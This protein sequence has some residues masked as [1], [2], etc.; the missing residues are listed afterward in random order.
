MKRNWIQ[1]TKAHHKTLLIV[2]TVV[3]IL[4]P[5]ILLVDPLIAIVVSF[6]ADSYD[7]RIFYF[8]KRT[9][10]QSWDKRLDAWWYICVLVYSFYSLSG[11]QFQI[12]LGLFLFRLLGQVA[13][14]V[15]KDERLFIVFP[16]IFENAFIAYVLIYKFS[17]LGILAQWPQSVLLWVI[18]VILKMV[19]EWI[20]HFPLAK[21]WEDRR[22]EFCIPKSA[23][24]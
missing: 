15:K 17:A 6:I 13:Y 5:A 20:V 10:Y 4:V 18:I 11:T 24:V 9:N 22:V 16:N 19:Q 14:T 21:K 3:R 8:K 7:S 1:W 23:L 2:V 12:L